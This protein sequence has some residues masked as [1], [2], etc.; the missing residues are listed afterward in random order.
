MERRNEALSPMCDSTFEVRPFCTAGGLEHQ[1]DG[2][3]ARTSLP[4]CHHT[5][6][7]SLLP[8]SPCWQRLT[9]TSSQRLF[10]AAVC[11]L[12]LPACGSNRIFIVTTNDS[13]SLR[14]PPRPARQRLAL[15][16]LFFCLSLV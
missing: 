8:N 7:L 5:A 11:H 14:R 3:R 2:V 10:A 9:R 1:T 13:F 15:A 12:A 4:N 6:H 16:L